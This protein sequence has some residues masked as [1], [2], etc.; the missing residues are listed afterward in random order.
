MSHTAD[1]VLNASTYGS[2]SFG[3][4]QYIIEQVTSHHYVT[5]NC[6]FECTMV[7]TRLSSAKNIIAMIN[8]VSLQ[9]GTEF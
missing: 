4:I 5:M 2:H 9:K 8:I 6:S 3:E 1:K 7:V